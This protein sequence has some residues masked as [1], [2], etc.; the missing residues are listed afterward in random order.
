MT[1]ADA[2]GRLFGIFGLVVVLGLC[3]YLFSRD[4]V[5]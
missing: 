4:T 3:V 5:D 1:V 2:Y